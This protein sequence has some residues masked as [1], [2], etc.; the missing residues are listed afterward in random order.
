MT[1]QTDLATQPD[2]VNTA[3][4][5]QLYCQAPEC[6]SY[7]EGGYPNVTILWSVITTGYNNYH[8]RIL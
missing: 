7:D 5:L 4:T 2:T 3:G 8:N 1:L 6:N